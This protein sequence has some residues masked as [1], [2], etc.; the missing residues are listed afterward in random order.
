MIESVG[1]Y[2]V[3]DMSQTLVGCNSP[4]L[5]DIGTRRRDVDGQEG[6]YMN[7]SHCYQRT[8]TRHTIQRIS[9][10]SHML[11]RD[12]QIHFPV[13]SVV[14]H[15]NDFDAAREIVALWPVPE[16]VRELHAG[17]E[18]CELRLWG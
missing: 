6:T 7:I 3:S 5:D 14:K 2:Q 16:S 11:R 4:N 15:V 8:T 10:T 17:F 13:L 9:S 1:Q 18:R 12:Q